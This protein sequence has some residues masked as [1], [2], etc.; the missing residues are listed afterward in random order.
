L[1]SDS[2]VDSEMARSRNKPGLA[3][4]AT[5]VVTVLVL[6]VASFGAWCRFNRGGPGVIKAGSAVIWPYYP[7]F[8]LMDNGPAPVKS[9]IRAYVVWWLS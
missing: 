7:M 5:V 9:A 2:Q 4:W 6:Y 1:L 8:W 3:F